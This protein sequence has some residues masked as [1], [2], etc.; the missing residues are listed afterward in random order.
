MKSRCCRMPY[1]HHHDIIPCIQACILLLHPQ[2]PLELWLS[3]FN[4]SII[5]HG[6]TGSGKTALLFGNAQPSGTAPGGLL[7]WVLQQA[8]QRLSSSNET[9]KLGISCYDLHDEPR[10]LLA[11][12]TSQ[13]N[14]PSAKG[15]P[16]PQD[17]LV[18]ADVGNFEESGRVL[19]A[20]RSVSRNWEIRGDA[21]GGQQAV[22]ALPN[23]AHAFVRLTL[24]R[25]QGQRSTLS[26]LTFVDLAGSQPLAAQTAAAV[27]GSKAT[28]AAPG[29]AA[30]SSDARRRI[31]SQQLASF[32]KLVTDLGMRQDDTSGEWIGVAKGLEVR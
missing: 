11:L 3:G 7:G 29:A 16:K 23:G 9:W 19:N 13:G 1:L 10:D 25:G 32:A 28:G 4:A 15:A 5:A 2:E 12:A 31:I 18:C 17:A 24:V 14:A 22:Y 6:L 21:G 30:S 20:A 8:F 26:T 27:A